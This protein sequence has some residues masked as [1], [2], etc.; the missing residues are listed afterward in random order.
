MHT[1]PPSDTPGR[2]IEG[3]RGVGRTIPSIWVIVP[4]DH[5]IIIIDPLECGG[6]IEEE[7]ATDEES[8]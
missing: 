8:L 3:Q 7:G 5:T 2:W 6:R 4:A 1:I